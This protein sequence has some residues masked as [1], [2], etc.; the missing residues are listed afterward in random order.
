M[1][2]TNFDADMAIPS[3]PS[4]EKGAKMPKNEFVTRN[5]DLVGMQSSEVQN[6]KTTNYG[7]DVIGPAQ[8]AAYVRNQD[9]KDIQSSDGRDKGR[10]KIQVSEGPGQTRDI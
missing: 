9:L 8:M 5:P 3:N 6:K 4:P 1:A 10:K 7:D 2:P